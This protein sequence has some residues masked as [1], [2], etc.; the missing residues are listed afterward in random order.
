MKTGLFFG[1]FNP[2]HIGH[3]I[4]ASY[5]VEF[6]DLK[7]VCLVVSPQNPEKKKNT[8][9]S[10]HHRLMIITREIED[11]PKLTVS[12]IE[13]NLPKP[14]YT[15]NTLVHLKERF[16]KKKFCLIMGADNLENFHKWKNYEQILNEH[17]I[18][19]YPRKGFNKENI[20]HKNIHIIEGVPE[21]QIS[22]SF[23]R[24]QIQQKKDV[25]YMMPEKSWQYID[26]MNFYK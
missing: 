20:T 13:F 14:N 4:I 24:N 7:Q 2:F 17:Q 18:Y 23:I 3:K 26:Q 25:S 1:S 5:M 16:P 12:D 11:N 19:V 22:A 21:I 9:L 8:L 10:Q 15:I 6:T